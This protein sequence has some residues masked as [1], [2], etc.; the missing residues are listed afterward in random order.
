MRPIAALLLVV[1]A[2]V[3]AAQPPPVPGSPTSGTAAKKEDAWFKKKGKKPDNSIRNLTGTVYDSKNNRVSGAVV[4]LTDTETGNGQEVVTGKDGLYRFDDTKREVTY[5]VT[6]KYNSLQATPRSLT[7]F[8]TRDEPNL[9]LTLEA[10]KSTPKPA[11]TTKEA[12]K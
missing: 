3:V 7:P 12:K 10:P 9:N 4:R 6:A 5:K 1:A 8:D 2:A 11:P